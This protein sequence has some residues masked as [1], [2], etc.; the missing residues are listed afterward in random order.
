ME[1]GAIVADPLALR[2][3]GAD[4]ET[5]IGIAKSD[6]SA[7]RQELPLRRAYATGQSRE[8][9]IVWGRVR[10]SW[11]QMSAPSSG[12]AVYRSLGSVTNTNTPM[13]VM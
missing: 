2:I 6:P 12:V 9:C 1:D 5:I 13:M 4:A 11:Q 10:N 7:E 8:I 3:L